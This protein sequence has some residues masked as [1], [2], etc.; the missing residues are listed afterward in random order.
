MKLTKV[1]KRV[2]V[3]QKHAERGIEHVERLLPYVNLKE[4]QNYLEVGCG[5]GHTC[6][7]YESPGGFNEGPNYCRRFSQINGICG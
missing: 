7:G 2:M 1:E 5:N 4:N 6:K 3:S